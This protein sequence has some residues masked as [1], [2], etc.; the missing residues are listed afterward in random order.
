[1]VL[2][3]HLGV[4]LWFLEHTDDQLA[5]VLTHWDGKDVTHLSKRLCS[6]H[7]WGF[8]SLV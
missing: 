2:M 1:M 6:C 4:L 8:R 3:V 5:F 7:L